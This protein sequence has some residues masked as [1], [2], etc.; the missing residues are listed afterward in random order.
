MSIL[1][2]STGF[3]ADGS[4]PVSFAPDQYHSVRDVILALTVVPVIAASLAAAAWSFWILASGALGREGAVLAGVAL[5]AGAAAF[6][7]Y[8]SQN[9]VVSL[10]TAVFGGLILLIG[11][12][13]GMAGYA[14]ILGG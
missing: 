10:I 14:L 11:A 8:A 3:L 6:S 5:V 12:L 2:A 4:G 7:R 13:F 9:I 1:N